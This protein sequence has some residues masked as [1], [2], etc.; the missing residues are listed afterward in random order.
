MAAWCEGCDRRVYGQTCEICGK[1]PTV[2][3]KEPLGWK[4]KL[5]LAAS[6]VYLVWRVYQ[7][8]HWLTH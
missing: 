8:V 5:F 1:A 4:W 3:T 6:V 7:L 2:P